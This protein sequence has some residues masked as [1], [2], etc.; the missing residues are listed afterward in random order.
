MN[1]ALLL[2]H[3]AATWTMVGLIWFVQVVHYPLAGKVGAGSFAAYQQAHMARTSWV[4]GPPMLIELGA[5]ALLL[6]H[7]PA[8]VPAWAP[9]VGAGLL[10]AVWGSTAL[11][12]VPLHGAL[13]SGLDLDRVARLVG[14]N[15]IR[16][17]C[18]SLRGLLALGLL[19]WAWEAR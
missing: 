14:T 19:A 7:R 12:Q 4:V 6:L 1:L 16:T 10:A 5:T 9:W 3:A 15:W 17:A 8:G 18:W 2:V 11:L 13:T